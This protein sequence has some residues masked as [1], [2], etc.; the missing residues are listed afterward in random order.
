MKL[1]SPLKVGSVELRNRVVSTAHAAF[2]DFWQPGSDG[3]RYIAYQERR[4]QG[5]TGLIVLTAA[6]VHESSSYAGHFQYEERDIARKYCEMSTRVH[7]HGARVVQ[8]LF[9]VGVNGK[10]DFR[11]DLHPLWGFSGTASAEGE[12]SHEMTDA[13]IETIIQGFVDAAVIAVENGLD[14]VELH[15]THGYLL[16]QS[17]SPFANKRKDK[18]GE[19]LC[20]AKTLAT[21][22][23]NAIGSG[24][25]LGLRLCI[26]DWLKPEF[27]GVGHEGLCAIGAEL[28]AT[29]LFDYLNHSEGSTGAHYARTIGSYRY[30][31]GEFLPL[32]RGLKEAIKSAVPVIGVGK[33]PTVDLAEKALQDGD[34]DLVGMTRAQISDPDLVNKAKAGKTHKIR[35][36]TGAN[37]GC[38][39]RGG[40]AL[41]ISCIHNPEVGEED[42]FRELDRRPVSPKRVLVVGGGPAGM[43]AA[44]IAAR[45]GHDVT[46]V[47]ASDR[48][49]GRL[50]LVQGFGQ[51]ASLL[52]SITW[53]EQELADLGV[54]PHLQ[55]RVDEEFVRKL[56]PDAIILASGATA[57]NDPG[58][59]T[60]GSIPILSVDQAARCEYQGARIDLEG[61]RSV[62]LDMR[63]N[64]ETAL[65]VEHLAKQ[66]SAVIVATPYLHFG[67]NMGF[68][69]LLDYHK[70]LPQWGVDVRP[71]H[72][73]ASISDGSVNLMHAFSGAITAVPAD[74]VVAGIHPKP[75]TQ[76]REMLERH[77][78][79]TLVGDVMAPRSALE[80]IREG[81][82]AARTLS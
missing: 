3:Q 52:G 75:N 34:C 14:G 37:Q 26:E 55:A 36:C 61:T 44:E 25:L 60:D 32:T 66:G 67:A 17:F 72:V 74:L 51:A 12:A 19:H 28:I 45:R 48:L 38:I 18:W 49:G 42:R 58:I 22:V 39:D 73:L 77:A 9:H 82:R 13:E 4:A 6:H 20:F 24:P 56:K 46:L 79:V 65:V 21:R 62:M 30:T 43:K 5:G 80:A 7:R 2:L 71:Q 78:P 27:G 16:Q 68:T 40:F 81:D 15:G 69:H 53:L 57:S 64:Y 33:I 63:G 70:L 50:N 76:L 11:P 31:Y 47:E 1:L 35:L 23:R 29:G 41:P 54:Q 59:P 10:S 8:Q